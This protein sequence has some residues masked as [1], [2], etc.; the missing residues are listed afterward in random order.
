MTIYC[1]GGLLSFLKL[2]VLGICIVLMSIRINP[3]FHFDADQ[4]LD[5]DWHQNNANPHAD[6][7]PHFTHIGK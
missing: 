6:P 7:T 1:F 2:A 5:A 4:D 3:T